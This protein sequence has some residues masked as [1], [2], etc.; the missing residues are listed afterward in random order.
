MK[1]WMRTALML[2]F[3][4]SLAG[5]TT[6]QGPPSPSRFDGR[7]IVIVANGAS[8]SMAVSDNL[9]ELAGQ[10]GYAYVVQPIRWCR[11]DSPALD[12]LDSEAQLTAAARIVH[13]IGMLKK[14]CPNSPIILVGHSAGT[15]VVLAAAESLPEG[16]VDRII[17]LAS[18]VS[19]QYD[20][21]RALKASKG[22][23]DSFYSN[24]DLVLDLAVEYFGTSDGGKCAAAGYS[25]FA[26]PND[27][28]YANLRQYRYRDGVIGNG[29]HFIWTTRRNLDR[30][31]IPLFFT[32]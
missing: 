31:I 1:S 5:I 14:D 21:R 18:S 24:D 30:S 6:A 3:W 4:T 20:L 11:H 16:T 28:S 27:G 23:I 15:R 7:P 9:R 19:S 2:L 13:G 12:H 29:G 17:L 22:G 25:G 8:G 32:P 26:V 10:K